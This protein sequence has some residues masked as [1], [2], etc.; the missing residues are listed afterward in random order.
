MNKYA[1]SIYDKNMRELHIFN[2]G[3]FEN[4]VFAAYITAGNELGIEFPDNDE[5]ENFD[6]DEVYQEFYE[7]GYLVAVVKV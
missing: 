5:R 2:A 4:E 1:V 6:I 3:Y 7:H